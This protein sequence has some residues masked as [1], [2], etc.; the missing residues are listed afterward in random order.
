[1]FYDKRISQEVPADRLG[2]EWKG[3]ILRISGG[4]DLQVRR[5]NSCCPG[6]TLI[7]MMKVA[8]PQSYNR[9]YCQNLSNPFHLPRDSA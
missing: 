7:E 6:L 3:Y 5:Y 2:D 1:M 4:N 9:I 8:P